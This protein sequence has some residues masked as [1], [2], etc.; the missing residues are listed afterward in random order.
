MTTDIDTSISGQRY[1]HLTAV[2]R[3][4]RDVAC[5]CV[6]ERLVHVAAE[7]L[8]EGLVTSCGCQPAPPIFWKQQ[9]QL[10]ALL[11]RELDFTIAKAR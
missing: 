9:N 5:R 1:G 8:A 3:R 7:A 6:C 10:R 4:G 11:K 2:Y